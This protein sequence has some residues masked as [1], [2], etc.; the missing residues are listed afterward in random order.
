MPSVSTSCPWCLRL[1]SKGPR[2]RPAAPG[3]SGM[4][5][6][7]CVF[8]QRS[9]EDR[10]RAVW[11]VVSSSSPARLGPGSE[12][13]WGQPAVSCVLC[14]GLRARGVDQLPRVIRA[15]IVVPL[16]STD[17]PGRLSP[18]SDGPRVRPD[19]PVDSGQCPTAGGFDQVFLVT[20]ALLR[21]LR[22]Q[23][24][25]QG[26]SGRAQGPAGSTCCPG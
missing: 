4:C 1:G 19:V 17:C 20:H 25:V 10:A 23:P 21:S 24:A 6:R 16:G 8:D 12:C 18:G 11:P 13:P 5:P 3:D 9:R 26:D 22:I 14:P 7:F 2:C 15:R